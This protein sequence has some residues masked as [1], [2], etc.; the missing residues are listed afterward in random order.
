MFIGSRQFDRL[1][2]TRLLIMPVTFLTCYLPLDLG[3]S[4][5]RDE[6]TKRSLVVKSKVC[7]RK[8]PCVASK[9]IDGTID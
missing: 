5:S 6:F 2:E 8:L 4:S 1:V 3:S 7:A 9:W